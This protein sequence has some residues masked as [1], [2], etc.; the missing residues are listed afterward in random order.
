MEEQLRRIADAL[1]RLATAKEYEMATADSRAWA[2]DEHGGPGD[3]P[4][5]DAPAIRYLAG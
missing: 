3:E 2:W 1:E 4:E 5:P